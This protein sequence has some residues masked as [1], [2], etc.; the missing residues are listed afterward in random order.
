M[1]FI[2]RN[3]VWKMSMKQRAVGCEQTHWYLL[4][5]LEVLLRTKMCNANDNKHEN[6]DKM[7]KNTKKHIKVDSRRALM[8]GEIKPVF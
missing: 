8:C 4:L 7:D 1:L 5:Y 3:H 2:D 6:V